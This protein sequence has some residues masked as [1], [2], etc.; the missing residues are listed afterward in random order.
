VNQF[1]YLFPIALVNK[2]Q[3][4]AVG[5]KVNSVDIPYFEVRVPQKF[6]P[7]LI[8]KSEPN[9]AELAKAWEADGVK[10]ELV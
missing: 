5:I 6:N 4:E 1:K 9:A 8:D 3:L 10:T 7:L 2:Q